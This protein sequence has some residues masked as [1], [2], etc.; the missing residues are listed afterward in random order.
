LIE[1]VEKLRIAQFEAFC[2]SVEP[3][4]KKKKPDPPKKNTRSPN[5]FESPS[6]KKKRK[7]HQKG[8]PKKY[9]TRFI[10]P[11]PECH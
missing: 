5:I 4:K 9:F 6:N 10:S 7:N 1:E 3:T 8:F 11:G 2:A